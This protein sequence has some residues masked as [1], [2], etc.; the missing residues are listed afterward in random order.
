MKTV[1]LHFITPMICRNTM[2]KIKS[3]YRTS[4]EMIFPD[5]IIISHLS[6]H[7]FIMASPV[8][9]LIVDSKILFSQ[10]TTM[11]RSVCSKNLFAKM[12]SS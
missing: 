10:I 12:I 7:G 5:K 4:S 8:K 3:K 9:F 1:D 11:I 2:M 6:K